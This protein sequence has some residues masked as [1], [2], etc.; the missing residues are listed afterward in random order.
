MKNCKNHK[1]EHKTEQIENLCGELCIW[2][3]HKCKVCKKEANPLL[4]EKLEK[5][6][7]R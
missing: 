6:N 2:L 4:I 7:L 3:V 5:E 1:W